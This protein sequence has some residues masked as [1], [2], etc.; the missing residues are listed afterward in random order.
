VKY[1]HDETNV[2]RGSDWRVR[3]VAFSSVASLAQPARAPLRALR[4]AAVCR[5]DGNVVYA[6]GQEVEPAE[7][8][9][10]RVKT[11][12]PNGI[13]VEID[14]GG[15]TKLYWTHV[16]RLGSLVAF[17]G[18]DGSIRPDGKL[19]Y[20]AWG[21]RR[22]AVDHSDIG[23]GINGNIDNRGF[24]GHE[25]LDQLDLVHMNGRIYDPLIAKFLSADPL[26]TDPANGQRYNRFSY[27]LNNPTNLTD[28]TGFEEE[29]VVSP[30]RVDVL[31]NRLLSEW[32]TL[33]RGDGCEGTIAEM[34]KLFSGVASAICGSNNSGCAANILNRLYNAT[35]RKL[36]STKNKP[37]V[38]AGNDSTAENGDSDS[39]S[40][41]TVTV[42]G[43]KKREDSS[44]PAQNL[45]AVSIS[46]GYGQPDWKIKW[47]LSNPSKKGG[48]IVQEIKI[49]GNPAYHYW[50]AWKVN[51]GETV[52]TYDQII[53]YD[54]QF[55][56]PGGTTIDGNA[57]FY[58]GLTLP[59][60]FMPG[61]APPSGELPSTYTDP[62]L[63]IKN[64]TQP[65]ERSWTA[66]NN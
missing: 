30:Q 63:P 51:S 29:K 12:W 64:S 65:V 35:D 50:E 22:S 17:T 7:G 53:P 31:E 10:L 54:D 4:R 25:M 61:F 24:T 37:I 47:R 14:E 28:P 5:G 36:R 58:E 66:P 26:I 27:V 49:N 43:Q 46:G 9:G 2:L 41:S 3:Y 19:E 32:K 16:D 1:F 18:E 44:T 38:S 59:R 42:R 20:D 39:N 62:K 13:G 56:A 45:S 34:S 8:G 33:C 23:D 11:Y 57:R 40:A 21:K 60:S 6:G 52:T 15:A 55:R 48:Y